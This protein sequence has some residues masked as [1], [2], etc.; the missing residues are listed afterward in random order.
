MYGRT[1]YRIVR[2][3]DGRRRRS[4]TS[5]SEGWDVCT[6]Y[7]LAIAEMDKL[8]VWFGQLSMSDWLNPE[9]G[10]AGSELY[11]GYEGLVVHR[12]SNVLARYRWGFPNWND[13]KRPLVNA[14]AETVATLRTFANAFRETR[15]LV[16]ADGYYEYR[17]S[18]PAGAKRRY[19]F[20]PPDEVFAFPGLWQE[21]DGVRYYTI[22]TTEPNEAAREYHNRMPAILPRSDYDRWLD[23]NAKPDGLLGLLM[24]WA[25]PLTADLKAKEPKTGE[26]AKEPKPA[27]GKKEKPAGGGLFD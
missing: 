2:I 21:R 8:A 9:P 23:P 17:G 22:L 13:P 16:P 3:L 19:L 5:P 11:P 24:P 18:D 10:K 27:K 15:C 7:R 25:G 6:N 4:V 12:G 26:P 20:R 1:Q 14:K